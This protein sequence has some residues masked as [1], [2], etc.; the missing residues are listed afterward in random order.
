MRGLHRRGTERRRA[1]ALARAA[2]ACRTGPAFYFAEALEPRRL[3]AFAPAGPEFLVNTRTENRQHEAAVAA[4]A[5]GDFVVAW[6]SNGQDNGSGFGVYAQ[7]Y[8]AAGVPRGP[9]FLVNTTVILN[10]SHPAV[11]MDADGDFVIAWDGAV[12][13]AVA[14]HEVY[15][16]RYNAAG[17]PQ[18]GETVAPAMTAERQFRPAVAMDA[19]GDFVIAWEDQVRDGSGYGIFARRFNSAGA[20]QGGDFPVNTNIGGKQS[21]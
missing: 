19:D 13:D 15:F 16:Q 8:S 11:A 3:L 17:V 9:E 5:D 10:Q 1:Q 21:D 7:R 14:V 2:G 4:D 20:A 12:F 18:G 6:T